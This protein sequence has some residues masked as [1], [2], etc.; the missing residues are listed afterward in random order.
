MGADQLGFADSALSSEIDTLSGKLVDG[1]IQDTV[2]AAATHAGGLVGSSVTSGLV[3]SE[4]AANATSIVAGVALSQGV[5]GAQ[6][7]PGAVGSTVDS[8]SQKLQSTFEG[9][10]QQLQE[11]FDPPTRT[12]EFED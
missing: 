11:S 3:G 8:T 12:P 5:N 2:E 6:V 1:S 9:G 7:L 4:M 10:M